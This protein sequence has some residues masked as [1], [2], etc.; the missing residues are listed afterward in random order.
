MK[1]VYNNIPTT[2]ESDSSFDIFLVYKEEVIAVFQFI[3]LTETEE[4]NEFYLERGKYINPAYIK[5]IN[6]NGKID[7]IVYSIKINLPEFKKELQEVK[8]KAMSSSIFPGGR[9]TI[10]A[11]SGTYKE[12]VDLQTSSSFL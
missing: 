10:T 8:V 12:L 4:N 6:N 2:W 3:K 7:E 9:V 11:M 5:H 1:E